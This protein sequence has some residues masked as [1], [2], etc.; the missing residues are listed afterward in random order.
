MD[1]GAQ[2]CRQCTFEL[3]PENERRKRAANHGLAPVGGEL[4]TFGAAAAGALGIGRFLKANQ[5][6]RRVGDGAEVLVFFVIGGLTLAELRDVG[7]VLLRHPGKRVVLGSTG[8]ATADAVAARL[9][10]GF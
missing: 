10:P 2:L 6:A 1:I 9:F 8:L 4:A 5:A 7:D 3:A